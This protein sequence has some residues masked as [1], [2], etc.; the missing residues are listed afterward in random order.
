MKEQVIANTRVRLTRVYA[1]VPPLLVS[2]R[3]LRMHASFKDASPRL[4]FRMHRHLS[5]C[6]ACAPRAPYTA[7]AHAGA[8]TT[9]VGGEERTNKG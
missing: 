2:M 8:R 7:C 3:A 5:L 4:S 1:R 6:T 9:H